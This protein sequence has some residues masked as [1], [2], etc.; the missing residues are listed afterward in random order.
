[1][2]QVGGSYRLV[3]SWGAATA[4]KNSAHWENQGADPPWV[5]LI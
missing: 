1:M 3:S 4:T 2:Q 5:L